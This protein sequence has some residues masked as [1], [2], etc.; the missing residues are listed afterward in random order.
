MIEESEGDALQAAED[1]SN[2]DEAKIG[3]LVGSMMAAS[4]G[5]ATLY[6]TCPR[7][8]DLLGEAPVDQEVA[9]GEA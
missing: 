9:A 7:R 5:L 6:R 1:Q 8:G 3:I 4:M 2:S